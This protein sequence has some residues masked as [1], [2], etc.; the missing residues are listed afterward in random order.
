MRRPTLNTIS[1]SPMNMAAC[2]SDA[3]K[4]P[5]PGGEETGRASE[6]KA[7]SNEHPA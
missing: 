4:Q 2:L 7:R 1:P 6:S 3:R 5:R